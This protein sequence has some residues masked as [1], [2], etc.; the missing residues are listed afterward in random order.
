MFQYSFGEK[1]PLTTWIMS[2][3]RTCGIRTHEAYAAELKS[4]SKLIAV[5]ILYNGAS[6][7]RTCASEDNRS[8]VDRLRPLGHST[9]CSRTNWFLFQNNSLC[10]LFDSLKIPL[11]GF[12]PTTLPLRGVCSANWAKE[13]WLLTLQY[14]P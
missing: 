8:W 13:A 3:G 4:D 9:L 10:L 2:L 1:P 6:R 12:E 11:V 7:V 14:L 5:W